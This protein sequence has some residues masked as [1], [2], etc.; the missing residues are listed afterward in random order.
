IGTPCPLE[1]TKRSRSA[2]VGSP[3]RRR[4]VWKKRA[5]TISVAESEPPGWP[6]PA[7]VIIRITCSRN[8]RAIGRRRSASPFLTLF[9]PMA[10]PAVRSLP[11]GYAAGKPNGRVSGRSTSR[12]GLLLRVGGTETAEH[13]VVDQLRH[14]RALAADHALRIAPEF[15]RADLAHERVEV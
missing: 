3:G 7:A 5:V 4:S 6:E 9:S 1:M 14:R 13:L 2:Q 10:L 12:L 11:N 8:R 15:Q